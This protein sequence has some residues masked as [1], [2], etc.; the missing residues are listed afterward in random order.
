MV[1]IIEPNGPSFN[2]LLRGDII[3]AVNG[4][5]VENSPREKVIKM[6]Q[7]CE[8][9]IEIK[10]RQPTYQELI[11][12]KNLSDP[13]FYTLNKSNNHVL[14]NQYS[15]RKPPSPYANHSPMNR[16]V[17]SIA[18]QQHSPDS[19]LVSNLP[20][21]NKDIKPNQIKQDI[22]PSVLR[23]KPNNGTE[24]DLPSRRF[25]KSQIDYG[26]HSPLPQRCKSSMDVSQ[27]G[28]ANRRSDDNDHDQP[29]LK[30]SNTMRPIRP[31][32]KVMEIFEVVI[33]I[34]FEVG[35]TRV[36]SYNQD[37]TVG[38]I[39]ET[40]NSRLTGNSPYSDEIKR[41]FGLAVTVGVNPGDIPHEQ[42]STKPKLLH[43]LNEN[44]S[45]MKMRQLP[46]ASK[47][48][49]LYR[50]VHPPADVNALYL[51]DKVAFE[52]LYQQSCNDLKLERF[53]PSLDQ[54]TALKLSGLHLLEYVYSHHSKAH[55]NSK[56]PK[57]YIKLVKKVPGVEYFLPHSMR[58]SIIDK[59]GKRV[60]A[61]CKKL[62]TRLREQLKKNFEEFDFEPPK[63]KSTTNLNRYSTTSF[64]ELSLPEL[65][66]S[67][68]E[69]VKLLFLNYLSQLP[70][71]GNYKQPM[72]ASASPVERTSAGECSSSSE[73]VPRT[74]DSSPLI[75]QD[76]TQNNTG[77]TEINSAC[78]NITKIAQMNSM[79]S[80][81]SVHST[82][83][84]K[85][86]DQPDIAQTP[87]IESISSITFNMQNSPSP[88]QVSSYISQQS[89]DLNARSTT[90]TLISEPSPLPRQQFTG[91]RPDYNTIEKL[92]GQRYTRSD[93]PIEEL[94]KN[95]ILL[96]P[97]PPSVSSL[98][99]GSLPY[100]IARK[101]EYR[102]HS[103]LTQVLTD[104]DLDK[105]RVPPPP[106]MIN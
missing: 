19:V 18:Q 56:D 71:Y 104:Q 79:R 77:R 10:V 80:L 53:C 4:I 76:R 34:F 72:R 84:G 102:P 31:P 26:R 24:Q 48:R 100:Q 36:L 86:L 82:S 35:H 14:S 91:I 97:P 105:L 57:V 85:P 11:R 22:M 83:I 32:A 68:S 63:V 23:Q 59:K 92:Y 90:N 67:P 45:I 33:K 101:M 73:S 46:Y 16:L 93:K 87:S 98:S 6:I 70:C 81:N 64:H 65:Q 1:K 13:K 40:L 27:N 58:Q 78:N 5:D 2:R 29:L 44:D 25:G 37:T 94:L 62:R 3:M 96:P 41:Y 88:Q 95:V 54:D 74:S 51:Q 52:Y 103:Q 61:Q 66:S 30:R 47:L 69:Y 99:L 8:D 89:G 28:G 15:K 106:R 17:T 7:L 12:A 49:L 9:Q 42:Q 50:M 75:R 39:L 21:P 60:V 38:A 43:V 55:D 20:H